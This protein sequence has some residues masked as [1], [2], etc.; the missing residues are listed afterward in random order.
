MR[1][2][3]QCQNARCATDLTGDDKPRLHCSAEARKKPCGWVKCPKCG[4][5]MD[6]NGHE[7]DPA[8]RPTNR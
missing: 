3:T 6:T 1:L 5:V 7:F 8:L 2:P 4:H